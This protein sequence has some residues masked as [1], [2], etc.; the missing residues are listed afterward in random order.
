MLLAEIVALLGC[1]ELLALVIGF[2]GFNGLSQFN[3]AIRTVV[4]QNGR[5]TFHAGGGIVADS[6]P[7]SEYAE[8]FAKA[9]GIIRGINQLRLR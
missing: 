5:L 2:F 8:T 7:E 9:E 3:V 1:T 4:Y 6:E